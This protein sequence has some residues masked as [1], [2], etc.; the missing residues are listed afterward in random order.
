VYSDLRDKIASYE[1]ESDKVQDVL[2]VVE[3]LFCCANSSMSNLAKICQANEMDQGHLAYD[4]TN[5]VFDEIKVVAMG[6][7]FKIITEY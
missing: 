3:A 4:E 1:L 5:H 2:P 7:I 6:E